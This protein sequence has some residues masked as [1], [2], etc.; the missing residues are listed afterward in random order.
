MKVLHVRFKEKSPLDALSHIQIE[1]G[2]AEQN[3]AYCL[4]LSHRLLTRISHDEGQ[5]SRMILLMEN[6]CS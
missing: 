2:W 1:K 5:A 6:M 3:I 4:F